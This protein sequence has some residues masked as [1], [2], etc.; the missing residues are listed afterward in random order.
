M[1]EKKSE[2]HRLII[3]GSGPAG[4]TAALYAARANLNPVM[5]EGVPRE[6]ELPGGQLMITTDVENYPGF[7]KGIQG[8]ELMQL[9]RAQAERFNTRIISDYVAKLELGKPPFAMETEEGLR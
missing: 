8:P 9:F 7:P 3:I 6:Y 1:A 4:F 5:I 2:H